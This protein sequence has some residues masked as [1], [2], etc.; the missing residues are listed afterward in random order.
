ML[1]AARGAR[2]QA[3]VPRPATAGTGGHADAGT[4]L[5]REPALETARV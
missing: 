1:A 3:S 4:A 5:D 2:R